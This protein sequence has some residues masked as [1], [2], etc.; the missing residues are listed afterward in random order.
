MSTTS[1]WRHRDHLESRLASIWE[2][3][4]GVDTVMPQ[5]N[6]FHLGGDS[7]RALLVC[8]RVK[9]ELGARLPDD[10]IV[11]MAVNAP[12]LR[13]SSAPGSPM[14]RSSPWPWTLQP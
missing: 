1:S 9:A 13:T 11:A 8:A 7:V 5:D 6:F 4:L 2:T 3:T 12:T 14:T 10:A